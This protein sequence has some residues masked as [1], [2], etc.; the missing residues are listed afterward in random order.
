MRT[1]RL[2]INRLTT[3]S[4]SL[5][6]KQ[7]STRWGRVGPWSRLPLDVAELAAFYSL[8]SLLGFFAFSCQHFS[9]WIFELLPIPISTI[10]PLQF[11]LCYLTWL[12]ATCFLSALSQPSRLLRSRN[13]GYAAVQN[14]NWPWIIGNSA[15]RGEWQGT[16]NSKNLCALNYELFEY[17]ANRTLG[18]VKERG[19]KI[20]VDL[21][22][23]LSG[24]FPLLSYAWF[25][26][27][28]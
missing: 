14:R 28:S 3:P 27:P 11:Y 13:Q 18:K 5:L 19:K 15:Q 2:D 26:S 9:S 21:E 12:Q 1:N 25:L 22:V 24:I 6:D 20:P 7:L 16:E 10:L 23:V 17:E 4:E 8:F